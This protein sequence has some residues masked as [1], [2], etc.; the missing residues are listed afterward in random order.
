[1][2]QHSCGTAGAQCRRLGSCVCSFSLKRSVCKGPLQTMAA[3]QWLWIWA[4]FTMNSLFGRCILFGVNNVNV[5][6][7][8]GYWK[9]PINPRLSITVASLI[10][11]TLSRLA[12][13]VSPVPGSQPPCP[14][15]T[16]VLDSL[17]STWSLLWASSWSSQKGGQCPQIG[18]LSLQWLLTFVLCTWPLMLWDLGHPALSLLGSNF[19]TQ[20]LSVSY[21]IFTTLSSLC[22]TICWITG[23]P[24]SPRNSY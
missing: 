15:V 2:K 3:R 1:M 24:L 4:Q 23:F 6:I 17:I 5:S 7:E 19:V 12:Y 16:R 8:C 9:F 22:T 14:L 13:A 18:P 20:V 10:N 11:T 21:C